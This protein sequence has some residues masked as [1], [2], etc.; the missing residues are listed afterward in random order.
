[1]TNKEML[2]ECLQGDEYHQI[3]F[4]SSY[5]ECPYSRDSDCHNKN[6]YGTSAHQIYCDE[7]CK[8][9]WLNKEFEG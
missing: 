7:V 2:I 1:M 6:E 8:P 4:A 3:T 5:I 9:E